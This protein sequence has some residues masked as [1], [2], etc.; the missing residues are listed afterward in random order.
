MEARCRRLEFRFASRP[1]TLRIGR[2]LTWRL[3]LTA[4]CRER[5]SALRWL[6]LLSDAPQLKRD[7]LDR[8]KPA[9]ARSDNPFDAG[10]PLCRA[11]EARA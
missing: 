9:H 11:R 8:T 7:R 1:V 4:R 5:A 2:H 3:Q 6:A 10:G